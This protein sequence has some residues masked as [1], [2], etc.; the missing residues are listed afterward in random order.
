MFKPGGLLGPRQTPGR[1]AMDQMAG[2]ADGSSGKDDK[3]GSDS[4]DKKDE[5][6]YSGSGFDP[7]GL[8]RAAK[9]AQVC[10][11]VSSTVVSVSVLHPEFAE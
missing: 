3:G 9:A 11:V 6:S 10:E 8:E 4:K 5:K 2:G 7:R 1:V